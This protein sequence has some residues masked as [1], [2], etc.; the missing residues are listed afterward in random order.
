[1]RLDV[2]FGVFHLVYGTLFDDF[3]Q[4]FIPPVGAHLSLDHVLADGRQ[5]I[6]QK[7]IEFFD[8][9]CHYLS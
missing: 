2:L 7:K 9:S 5:F 8:N 1:M 4:M 6:C 3:R